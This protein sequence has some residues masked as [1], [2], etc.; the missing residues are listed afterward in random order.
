[1]LLRLADDLPDRLG[2]TAPILE[3]GLARHRDEMLEVLTD[4]LAREALN[5]TAHARFNVVTN[6]TSS[7][8]ARCR[9]LGRL[10]RQDADSFERPADVSAL[11]DEIDD[12]RASL[13]ATSRRSTLS[14]RTTR[15]GAL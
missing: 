13:W 9:M 7:P 3:A 11:P 4:P 6:T 10:P 14:T 15:I 12:D 2:S 1:M 8:P 5:V